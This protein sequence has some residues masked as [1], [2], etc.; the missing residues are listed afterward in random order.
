MLRA[1]L[2]RVDGS[3]QFKA[4]KLVHLIVLTNSATLNG[5]LG[6]R[7]VVY[8]GTGERCKLRFRIHTSENRTRVNFGLS[9]LGQ[10]TNSYLQ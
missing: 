4:K 5:G 7:S 1:R 9:G 8:A 10:Q 3:I 6:T 2:Q